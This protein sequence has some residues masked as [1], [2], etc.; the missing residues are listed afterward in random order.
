ME[1]DSMI[2]KKNIKVHDFLVETLTER[3]TE[4]LHLIS[5]GLSNKEIANSLDITEN[6]VK[7][8]IKNIYN[9]LGVNR[10]V[11]VVMRARELNLLT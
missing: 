5:E 4:V 7:T 9:K 2:D 6:T 1:N 3:E 8:F 10:R 11:Q